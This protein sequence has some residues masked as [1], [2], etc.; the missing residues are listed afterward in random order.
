CV[1]HGQ[2]SALSAGAQLRT[3]KAAGSLK[4]SLKRLHRKS[5]PTCTRDPP[6]S[7]WPTQLH[8]PPPRELAGGRCDAARA[9]EVDVL[10]APS[11][12]NGCPLVSRLAA[13]RC[14]PTGRHRT[15]VRPER[16]NPSRYEST[17]PRRR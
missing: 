15:P 2:F 11:V 7:D 1:R 12:V 6:A 8:R 14:Q 5:P 3:L 4:R 9:V 10:M 17:D 16:A 13:D